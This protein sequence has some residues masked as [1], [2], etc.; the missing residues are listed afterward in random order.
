MLI[1]KT[2][3]KKIKN[4]KSGNLLFLSDFTDEFG[5][6]VVKKSLQRLEKNKVIVRLSRGIYYKP[7]KDKILGTLKPS[8]EKIAEAI[9][10]RDKARMIPTGSYALYKLGLSEQIPMNIVYLT[11]GSPR[12]IKI[13]TRKITFKKTSP[14]NLA[15]EHKL[16]NMLIQGLKELGEK[17]ITASTKQK[18]KSIIK[19]SEDIDEIKM[20]LLDAHVW[21]QNVIKPIIKDIENE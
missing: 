7:K 16:S 5:Y 1:S 13:G 9:A 17:N 2:I 11:D 6:E 8:L 14:K 12:V 18:I 19:Q 15:V 3:E 21:I 10:R 20:S 4:L